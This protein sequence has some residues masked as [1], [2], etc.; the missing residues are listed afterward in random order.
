MRLQQKVVLV[1]GAS[2]GIGWATCE[3]LASEGARVV[4]TSRRRPQALA[5]SDVLRVGPGEVRFVPGDVTSQASLGSVVEEAVDAYGRL[6]GVFANAG[7]LHAGGVL[8]A[9]EAEWAASVEVN[10]TAVWRT[11]RAAVPA[12]L[13]AGRGG[14]VV[15][16]SS[17]QGRRGIA[18]FGAYT[19]TKFGAVGLAQA[20]A[21]DLAAHSIRVN[22]VLPTS[23]D[24]PM[25]NGAEHRR[26]MTG[27]SDSHEDQQ[28]LYRGAH[29]L[30]IGWI[31]PVDVA[32]AVLWLLSEESRYVTGVDLPVDAGYL[33]KAV[34]PEP[35]RS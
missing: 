35:L 31:D 29:L 19:A 14:S 18:G 28:A 23:V 16:N 7:V 30:P 1:T 12:M 22:S 9:T 4:G 13:A 21:Q 20:L 2:G 6:D 34:A 25:I 17:V 3:R 26:R 11:V 32:N 8:D 24:T 10:L 33:A 5:G 15:V 27:G